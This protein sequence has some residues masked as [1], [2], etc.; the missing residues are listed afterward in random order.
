MDNLPKFS[1]IRSLARLPP[2]IWI[3]VIAKSPS[4][5]G[6]LIPQELS[7]PEALSTDAPLSAPGYTGKAGV[8]EAYQCGSLSSKC[9]LYLDKECGWKCYFQQIH[10]QPR[11]LT[12]TSSPLKKARLV[13]PAS[14]TTQITREWAISECVVK[15]P[16]TI[17]VAKVSWGMQGLR[18]A[19]A[20]GHLSQPVT[21]AEGTGGL[22]P[23]LTVQEVYLPP[24][25]QAHI[26]L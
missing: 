25:T 4:R 3:L 14:H 13:L 22:S 8:L 18:Q 6:K 23:L 21:M 19:H 10:T 24:R 1:C 2:L 16:N 15:F 11:R 26:C 7:H 20:T 12:P 9:I 17:S 5:L